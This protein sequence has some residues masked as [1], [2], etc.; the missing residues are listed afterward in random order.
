MVQGEQAT[1][2]A[3]KKKKNGTNIHK[4]LVLHAQKMQSVIETS[5]KIPE[6][7]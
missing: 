5:K 1:A 7:H 2:P 4:V 3:N 6:S